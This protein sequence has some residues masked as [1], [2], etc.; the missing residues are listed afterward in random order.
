M[1]KYRLKELRK[2]HKLSQS[3][4]AKTFN[5]TQT[6]ISRLETGETSAT[7]DII[8]K[9]ADYFGVTTDYLL[10]RTNIKSIYN[11]IKKWCYLIWLYLYSIIFYLTFFTFSFII[12]LKLNKKK[13]TA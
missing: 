13:P 5:I 4:L 8:N 11:Y 12:E 9:A 3:E 6:A 7:E 10:G 1:F 2:K